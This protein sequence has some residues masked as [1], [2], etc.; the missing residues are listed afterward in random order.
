M[1]ASEAEAH[2]D[3]F[4][5]AIAIA[6][7]VLLEQVFV[8]FSDA[9]ETDDDAPSR[10]RRLEDAVNVEYEITTETAGSSDVFD[11][12]DDLDAETYDQDL[13]TAAA[14][15]GDGDAFASVATAYVS[16]PATE[17]VEQAASGGGGSGDDDEEVAV[18]AKPRAGKKQRVASTH[19]DS[20]PRNYPRRG[21]G[22]SPRLV[23]T[24]ISASRPRRLSATRFHGNIRVA[25]AASL[26]DSFPRNYPRR[27]RGVSPRLV[28]TELS[29][30][31]PRR[32][33][34]TRF[35]GISAFP[36]TIR[37]AAAASPG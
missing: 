2:V 11:A 21:R 10:R 5:E 7:G 19:R 35:Y 28:S 24:G 6:A 18:L 17:A 34:A 33:S 1:T 31:R 25:A 26:R 37:V 22:V 14:T 32:L 12:M 29:A 8:S 36:R 4:R 23:S 16:T 13:Q 15:S 30:S 27:G 9:A 20:C 3:V